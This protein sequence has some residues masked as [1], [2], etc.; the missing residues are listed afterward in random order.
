MAQ[1]NVLFKLL[2]PA[3][4]PLLLAQ[5]FG[6]Y[7]LHLEIAQRAPIFSFTDLY[8]LWFSFHTQRLLSNPEPSQ[9]SW[10]NVAIDRSQWYVSDAKA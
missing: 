7:C 6:L 4:L 1:P 10:T 3:E 5:C 9:R 8:Q 2:L